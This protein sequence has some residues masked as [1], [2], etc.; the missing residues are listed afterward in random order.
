MNRKTNDI[1]SSITTQ[2][3]GTDSHTVHI[4]CYVASERSE[5]VSKEAFNVMSPRFVYPELSDPQNP[6]SFRFMTFRSFEFPLVYIGAADPPVTAPPFYYIYAEVC[7]I[8]RG[9]RV[10]SKH[11][12]DRV[13]WQSYLALGFDAP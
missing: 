9:S 4:Y 12:G 13:S 6:F 3:P 11:K 7:Y 5:E 2:R 8:T 10:A 1:N